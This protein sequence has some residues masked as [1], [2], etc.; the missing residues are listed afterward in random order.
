MLHYPGHLVM[1]AAALAAAL[2][3]QSLTVNRMVRRKLRLS[4]ALLSAYVLVNLVLAVISPDPALLTSDPTLFTVTDEDLH[5]I[6]RLAIAAAVINMLVVSLVN[7]LYADRVPERFP[8]IVQDFLVIG[9]VLLAGTFLSDKLIATSAVSAVVVGFALQDTLGNAFAGLAIQSEAPFH[10]GNWIR[11]GDFEGRV[12][13]VTWRATKLRTKSGNFVVVPNNTVAGHAIVNFTEPVGPTRLE[14]E[15]GAGYL[16][17]PN[18]VIAVILD[19]MRHVP[20]VLESPAPD[21]LLRDFAGSAITYRARFWVADYEFDDEAKDE[22]RTAIFYAFN[23]EEI[24]M[25]YPIEVG[26]RREWPEPDAAT[27][28]AERERL[29]SSVD[30]FAGLD[31]E[32][33]RAIAAR[34][35]MRTFGS[36]EAVVREGEPGHSMFIVCSGAVVVQLGAERADVATI[37][38]GGYFGEMSLLTGEPRTATVSARGDTTVL[39]LD[40]DV[41]RELAASDPQALERV[42]LAAATRRTEL[43]LA[44]S[45]LSPVSAVQARATLLA[46]MRNFLRLGSPKRMFNTEEQ[47]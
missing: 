8:T 19:A 46:R 3:I 26:Y 5:A 23:R 47:G 31:D 45:A 1:G 11:V 41:F 2:A 36:G 4:V 24:E 22:V 17:P 39:E 30:L 33:R 7:P 43:D 42:G 38:A 18:Q 37:G 14:V 27:K 32:Q 9:L 35:V 40:D 15:V 12:A 29:V 13:E 6:E 16:H 20:R 44:R 34:A 10:V 28:H 21:A 25:P